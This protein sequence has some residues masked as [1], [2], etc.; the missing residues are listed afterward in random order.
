MKLKFA[1][2]LNIDPDF[3]LGCIASNE[4]IIRVFFKNIN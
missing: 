3:L 2:D 1:K 4:E